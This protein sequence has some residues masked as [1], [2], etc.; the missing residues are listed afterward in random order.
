MFLNQSTLE[1]AKHKTVIAH[2]TTVYDCMDALL[3]VDWNFMVP[4]WKA[5]VHLL[6][7]IN[8]FCNTLQDLSYIETD[9]QNK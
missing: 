5:A 1:N 4:F 8:I 9:S 6:Y 2:S 7:W 3:W